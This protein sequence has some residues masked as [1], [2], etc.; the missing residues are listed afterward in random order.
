M[1]LQSIL[2]SF[3]HAQVDKLPPS[4]KNHVKS[5][6]NNIRVNFRNVILL[7]FNLNIDLF[8]ETIITIEKV[9]WVKNPKKDDVIN[10]SFQG[11]NSNIIV[12]EV[13]MALQPA[14]TLYVSKVNEV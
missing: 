11:G 3:I 4:L 10:V 14:T 13:T 8:L 6:Q 7:T 1:L 9:N 5:Q 2:P 12:N